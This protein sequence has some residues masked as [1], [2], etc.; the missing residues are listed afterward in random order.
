MNNQPYGSNN[1]YSQN[2]APGQFGPPPSPP[3]SPPLRPYNTAI[4]AL[5]VFCSCVSLLCIPFGRGFSAFGASLLEGLLISVL[6]MDWKGFTSLDGLITWSQIRGKKRFWFIC[7]YILFCPFILYGYVARHAFLSV[8]AKNRGIPQPPARK[9]RP[10]VG[11]LSGFIVAIIALASATG[12]AASEAALQTQTSPVA[13]HQIVHTTPTEKLTPSP[14]PTPLQSPTPAQTPIPTQQALPV[15]TGI[16]GNPYGYDLNPP[17]NLIYSPASDICSYIS[18]IPSFWNG[19]GYVEECQDD[20][21][22]K[23]GGISGSCSKHGGD[24]QPLYSH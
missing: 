21:F 14:T 20:L 22:S 3:V 19:R 4:L 1:P 8:D 18:C 12:N 16:G 7:A 17:G 15:H 13:T 5:L 6:I 23:S 2:Y 9:G 24:K 10:I 11:L